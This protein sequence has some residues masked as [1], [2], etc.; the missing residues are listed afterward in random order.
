M[1]MLIGGQLKALSRVYSSF[2]DWQPRLGQ[3]QFLGFFAVGCSQ[4]DFSFATQCNQY[5]VYIA[6]YRSN[7]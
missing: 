2:S 6:L 7:W 1:I 3:V 4:L 5:N